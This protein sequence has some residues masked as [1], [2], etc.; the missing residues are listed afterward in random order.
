MEH[1]EALLKASRSAVERYVK[2][3]ISNPFDA[4]DVL[5]EI[6]LAASRG[7]D[8]LKDK[9]LFKA[10]LIG[11]ARNKCNDY[12][13]RHADSR[14]LSLEAVADLPDRSRFGILHESPVSEA[15]DALRA[16]DREILCLFYY[17]ELSVAQIASRLQIPQGTV[18]SRLFTAKQHFKE[19]YPHRPK[20]K[21]DLMKHL[22]NL[23]P[24]YTITPS[25]KAPFPVVWE[26]MMGWF[27]VPKLG[28]SCTWGMYD[29][30]DG[31]LTEWDEMTVTGRAI[32]HGIEGVAITVKSHDPMD[33]NSEGGQKEVDRSFVA[34]LTDTH[35]RYLAESHTRD[36]ILYQYT[37][38]DGDAFLNNWG[39]GEDN[40]GNETHISEKGDITRNKN[41]VTHK[42]KPFLLDIVGRYAVTIG[43]KRYDTV[44][45]MDIGT[46]VEDMVT[47]QYLDKNGR[48]VLWRRFNRDDWRFDEYGKT[49]SEM[50]PESDRLIVNGKTYVHWYDCI[51][52]HIL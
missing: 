9:T 49:W 34:E 22:P 15:L 35:C 2:F 20:P 19:A 44:C 48:T 4:D 24:D 36:G 12:H 27:I 43:R 52:D 13:R 3:R 26:E 29:R 39:F 47:E 51:T 25:D 1:L 38:L 5:Q 6:Y 17:Q 7:F 33:C 16:K 8:T 14:E 18:K 30:P 10:W 40:C 46:Y 42:E 31:H 11:I 28:E 45:V 32:V 41:I 37:F 50:L 21:G 23:I